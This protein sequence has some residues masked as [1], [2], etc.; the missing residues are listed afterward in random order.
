MKKEFLPIFSVDWT[1]LLKRLSDLQ[2]DYG[3]LAPIHCYDKLLQQIRQLDQPFFIDSGVFA[4]REPPW[5]YRLHCEFKNHQPEP[6][7][8]RGRKLAFPR[9]EKRQH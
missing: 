6:L 7:L 9:T 8:D 2:G 4:D 5:Y 1:G 3:I